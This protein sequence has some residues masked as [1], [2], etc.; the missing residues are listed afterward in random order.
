MSVL[1]KS[2][3]QVIML[4]AFGTSDHVTPSTA[5]TMG[6]VISKNG[7]TFANPA[8]GALTAT[9]VSAGWYKGTLGTADTDTEGDL[10]V[11]GTMAAADPAERVFRVIM[12]SNFAL[13]SIDGS[14]RFDIAK[15]AGQ[16]ITA[17]A[18]VT[19]PGTVAS[20]VNLAGGTI[21]MALQVGTAA[22]AQVVGTANHF[23]TGGTVALAQAVTLA[24]NVTTV[25]GTVAANIKQVNDVTVLG[26]GA[27]TPWGP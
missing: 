27:G 23:L 1:Y 19:L 26:D 7:G 4:K 12:P 9:E 25:T 6:V 3:A 22:L 5:G 16:T 13:S 21:A 17:G 24:T 20:P 11:R 18:G 15:F 2:V 8:A 10:V 14:G